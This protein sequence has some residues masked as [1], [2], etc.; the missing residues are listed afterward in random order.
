MQKSWPAFNLLSPFHNI[1]PPLS[2]CL[3]LLL[4]VFE[5][6]YLRTGN[7]IYEQITRFWIKI[8]ALIFGIGGQDNSGI[9]KIENMKMF[10]EERY[11]LQKIRSKTSR[12]A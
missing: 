12:V 10:P 4:V 7:K 5:G 1:Y 6:M 8:F 11:K 9:N 2:S 3:G